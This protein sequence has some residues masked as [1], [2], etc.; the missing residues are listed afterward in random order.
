[1]SHI[2]FTNFLVTLTLTTISFITLYIY[3]NG[4]HGPFLYDDFASLST[5]NLNNRELSFDDMLNFIFGNSTG[6]LG[7]P[8]SMASFLL[9]YQSWPTESVAFKLTNIL[10]HITIGWLIYLFI[11]TILQKLDQQLPTSAVQLISVLTATIWLLHPLHVSTTLYTIQRMAQLST[12]F[13]ILSIIIFIKLNSKLNYSSSFKDFILPSLGLFLTISLAILSKENGILIFPI[14]ILIKR[15]INLTQSTSKFRIWYF[16]FVIAPSL[17]S[18]IYFIYFITESGLGYEFKGFTFQERLLT[19]LRVVVDYL[20]QIVIPDISRMS[21]F[22]DDIKLSSSLFDPISSFIS[23]IFLFSLLLIAYRCN[24]AVYKLAIAWFFIWHLLES[25]AIPLYLYF[26][27]RNYIASVGPI[28]GLVYGVYKLNSRQSNTFK[29]FTYTG[30]AAVISFLILSLN[31]LTKVWASEESIYLHQLHAH[32]RSKLTFLSLLQYYE[33]IGEKDLAY[34][35]ASQ[36]VKHEH[37][38]TDL[39]IYLKLYSYQCILKKRSEHTMKKLI[40]LSLQKDSYTDTIL[41][42]VTTLSLNITAKNCNPTNYNHLHTVIDNIESNS[43]QR[44]SIV[45]LKGL[46]EK[47]AY[48][49]LAEKKYAEA[50]LLFTKA[51]SVKKPDINLAIIDLNIKLNNYTDAEKWINLAEEHILSKHYGTRDISSDLAKLKLK[52]NQRRYN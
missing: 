6:Y 42:I 49:Y 1:M 29:Y 3:L 45:W 15:L 4:V 17:L 47:H 24:N 5:I 11:L 18:L 19:E 28:F 41:P 2:K 27:H 22:H 12:L 37:F 32:E 25:T 51:Y 48:I 16:V 35:L 9:N 21:I 52:L 8:V 36:G 46:Q 43:Y 7:R 34:K 38:K 23:L 13:S 14:L 20:F 31:T 30:V 39:S 10:I 44:V 40:N 33:N 26:E 50:L